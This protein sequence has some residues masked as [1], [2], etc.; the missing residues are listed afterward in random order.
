MMDKRIILMNGY[1]GRS[2]EC[3]RFFFLNKVFV[4]M[5]CFSMN[6]VVS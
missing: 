3:Y 4:H 1:D 6:T 5:V 2:Y